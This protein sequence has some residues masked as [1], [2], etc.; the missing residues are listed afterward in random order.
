MPLRRERLR[1]ALERVAPADHLDPGRQVLGRPDL[2]R[3][4]E[5]VEQLRAQLALLGIAAAD[6]D[7]PGRMAHAQALAL[8]Q[9]L[10]RGRDVEQEVD[11]MV[12]EQI[13]LVDV[14][15]AA[16]GPR[17]QAGLERLLAPGQR[18]LEVERAD[19][20]VLGRAQR[21]VDHRHR[22]LGRLHGAR[23]SA[24]RAVGVHRVAGSPRR[25]AV[26]AA[27]GHDLHLRQ[28][29]RQRP[30]GGGFAGA[31][32]AEHQHAADRLI[33][34]GDQQG[35]L[36][37]LLA[38]DGGEREERCACSPASARSAHRLRTDRDDPNAR[39]STS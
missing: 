3:E 28:Q 7:E 18:P 13:G 16:V 37:L 12:L 1:V 29:R 26:V 23:P 2:D 36:H 38:D 20:P 11:Q 9:V 6:Q 5:A 17:Q 14:E 24:Q 27:A 33:D 15:E 10:A 30:H 31:A 32:V 39:R 22:H 25:V 8:D 19:D 21:Q 4:P 34:R 35:L